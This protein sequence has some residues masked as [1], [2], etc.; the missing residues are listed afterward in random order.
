MLSQL[1]SVADAMAVG[2]EASA[3]ITRKLFKKPISLEFEKCLVPW[4]LS[5]KKRNAG[6][7]YSSN[8]NTPDKMHMTGIESNRRDN[9]LYL[10]TMM[11]GC[12]DD[13]L[14]KRDK[15]LAIRNIQDQIRK[16]LLGEIS[17]WLLIISKALGK[18]LDDET[19]SDSQ[20][21]VNLARRQKKRDVNSAPGQ[22]D[23]VPY[24]I[25]QG[26]VRDK[27]YQK[28]EDPLYALENDV[29]ID[30]DYYINNQLMKPMLRIMGAVLGS[31]E[32]AHRVLFQGDHM[33]K[34]RKQAP[35]KNTFA[36]TLMKFAKKQASC[37]VCK[38]GLKKDEVGTCTGCKLQSKD[39]VIKRK[40]QAE[41]LV[42]QLDAQVKA[43]LLKCA[44]CCSG[45]VEVASLCKSRDC[46]TTY[47]RRKANKDLARALHQLKDLSI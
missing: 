19:S 6:M 34:V 31:K 35:S 46:E 41:T 10:T 26:N 30:A 43:Y 4:L 3:H 11:T 2:K 36:T 37:L 5:G 22:G 8:P 15:T 28:S 42:Q 16:L 25:T 20:V 7:Y 14:I 29:P 17:M 13:L 18:P 38:I 32:K 40:Q 27:T 1:P 33:L 12:L 9:C 24:V 21:H 39:S 23:R 45:D 47:D 44:E